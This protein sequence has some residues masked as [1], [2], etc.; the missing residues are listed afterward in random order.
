[1]EMTKSDI[2]VCGTC[3]TVFHFVELFTEHKNEGCNEE[4]VFKDSVSLW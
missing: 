1:M 4:S 3:H 2:L